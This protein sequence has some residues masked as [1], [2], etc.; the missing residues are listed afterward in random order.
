MRESSTPG[1][2]HHGW[3]LLIR[4]GR[5]WPEIE[6]AAEGHVTIARQPDVIAVAAGDV[7]ATR[8]L[9]EFR[10]SNTLSS[11]PGPGAAAVVDRSGRVLAI[12]DRTGLHPLF[13]ARDG[14][15]W[16]LSTDPRSLT[17]RFGA[18]P[19]RVAVAAWLAGAPLFPDETLLEQVSRVPAG[20]LLELTGGRAKLRRSWE[21]PS[22]GSFSPRAADEFG[23]RLED[24]VRRW[25]RED[26]AAVLLSGG[27]DSSA[28]ATA[29]SRTAGPSPLALCVDFEGASE[30]AVQALVVEGLGMSHLDARLIA[31]PSLLRRGLARIS[32]SLWPTPAVWAPVFDSLVETARVAG[33]TVILDGQGGDDLLDAGLAGGRALLGRPWQFL[34]WA[35]AAARY[36]SSYRSSVR[37]GVASRVHP[38]R[39]TAPAWLAPDAEL[40]ARISARFATVPLEYGPLRRADLVD[41]T[42]AAQRE[43]TFDWAA[44]RGLRHLHPLWDHRV[45]ELLDGLPPSALVLGGEPKAPARRYLREHLRRP[46]GTWP[47]P[48]LADRTMGALLQ[49]GLTGVWQEL[50]GPKRLVELGVVREN[51]SSDE[52]QLTEVSAI[53]SMESWIDGLGGRCP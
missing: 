9:E 44:R 45:V 36:T 20:H 8:I 22:V 3:L 49:T 37:A 18:T 28:V 43:E 39:A 25:V 42:L 50:K 34:V 52:F 41:A 26:L 48:A 38:R 47:R 19:S 17:A 21:P 53:L 33:A 46:R 31:K 7:D 32:E 10:R 27:I 2:P 30:K 24:A 1:R 29:V 35:R 16:A 12:R 13:Y 40:R 11:P 4:P 6:T 23:P 51:P 5:T 14:Q 15:V